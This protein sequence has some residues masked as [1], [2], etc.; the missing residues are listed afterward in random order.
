MAVARWFWAALLLG[1]ASLVACGARS[2]L[3][4]WGGPSGAGGEPPAWT[5][6]A[7]RQTAITKVDLLLTLDNSISMADKQALLA[8]AVPLLV[9]RLITAGSAVDPVSGSSGGTG[10][11]LVESNRLVT[12]R[13]DGSVPRVSAL[14]AVPWSMTTRSA[15]AGSG[16]VSQH[17]AP[18]GSGSGRSSTAWVMPGRSR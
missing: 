12:S 17:R 8:E 16:S 9:Q 4:V 15:P 5:V 1:A 11:G 3:E 13:R 10:G 6:D 2:G 18:A 7:F 14:S